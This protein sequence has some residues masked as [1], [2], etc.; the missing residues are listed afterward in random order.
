MQLVVLMNHKRAWKILNWN[1]RG[2]NSD[3]K[4]NSIRDKIIESRCE[5]VCLQETKRQQFDSNYIKNFCPPDFDMF[6]FLPSVGASGGILVAWKSTAFLG[7]LVFS[8]CYAISVE[9]TSNMNNDTWLLTAIYAPCTAEGKRAFIHWF[10][11]IQVP[12]D[13][14]WLIV[15]DFNLIRKPQD[16]NRDGADAEEMFIFNEAISKLGVI[17][18]PL[19]GRQYTWTNKQFPLFSRDLIGF[20]LPTPGQTNS[21]TL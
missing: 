8:N 1:V 6:E 15:G 17:E 10:R 7:S 18:L 3:R 12:L 21:Q 13:L 5:I 16:R 4:W 20:S 11:E 9:F 14:D 2:L 19:H